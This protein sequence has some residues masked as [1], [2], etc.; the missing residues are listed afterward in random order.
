MSMTQAGTPDQGVAPVVAA[1]RQRRLHGRPQALVPVPAAQL[2]QR[3][4]LPGG[5]RAPEPLGPRRARGDVVSR[6]QEGSRR[7]RSDR[8]ASAAA[9]RPKGRSVQPRRP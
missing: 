5:H 6:T 1:Q 8:A 4:H 7:A 3:D 9:A 2:Q